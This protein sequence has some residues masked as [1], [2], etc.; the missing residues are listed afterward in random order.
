M[1]L[2]YSQAGD[3]LLPNV[4]LSDPPD[5]PPLGCCGMMHKRYLKEHRPILY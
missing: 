4:A 3:Y 2:T 5:A 1:E